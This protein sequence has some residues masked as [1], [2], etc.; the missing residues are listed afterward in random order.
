MLINK[1]IMNNQIDR[2]KIF[3]NKNKKNEVDNVD[4]KDVNDSYFK[5][6]SSKLNENNQT[7]YDCIFDNLFNN[8]V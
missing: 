5:Y 3:L 6:S 8:S 2:D 7:S 4:L 1:I